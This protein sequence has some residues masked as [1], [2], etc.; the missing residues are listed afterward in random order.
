MLDI[1]KDKSECYVHCTEV[2]TVLSSVIKYLGM[3]HIIVI[4]AILKKWIVVF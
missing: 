2:L 1:M 3:K 4:H